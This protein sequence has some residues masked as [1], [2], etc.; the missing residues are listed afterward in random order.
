MKTDELIA[1]LVDECECH[2]RSFRSVRKEHGREV[3]E[4]VRDECVRRGR[5]SMTLDA[6]ES[7]GVIVAEIPSE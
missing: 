5:G 6:Y 3:Y 2:G 7:D 1:E 4:A